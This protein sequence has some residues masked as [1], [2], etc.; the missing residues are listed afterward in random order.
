[1]REFI[2]QVLRSLIEWIDGGKQISDLQRQIYTAQGE[3]LAEMDETRENTQRKC[4]HKKGG[5]IGNL[6]SHASNITQ[7]LLKGDSAQYSVRKHKMMNGDIWVDCLRCGKKWRPPLAS[8]FKTEWMYRVAKSEY[9]RAVSFDTA[10]V[11][12]ESI[13]CNFFRD[14]KFANLEIREMYAA[15]GG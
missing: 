9:N 12:S 11:M 5:N 6:H 7:G 3:M 2:K 10:N 13:Q 14:G 8:D 15:I 1:M 4:N